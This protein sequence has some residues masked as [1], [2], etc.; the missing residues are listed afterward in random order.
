MAYKVIMK[1][2]LLIA[3]VV[4]IV[5]CEEDNASTGKRSPDWSLGTHGD[6]GE[7][8]YDIVFGDGDGV[9]EIDENMTVKRLDITISPG[10]W[11]VLKT[12]MDTLYG[13][14]EVDIN[15]EVS[16][17]VQTAEEIMTN[18]K[19]E[20]SS[21][22]P[23][24]VEFNGIKWTL[25]G[26]RIKGSLPVRE[27][28]R[29]G[30]Y[31]LPFELDFG[32]FGETYSAVAN[33]TFY[34]FDK[35]TLSNNQSDNSLIRE[36]TASDIFRKAGVPAPAATFCRLYVD[37]D[38]KG[39]KYFGMY[40]LAE[41]ISKSFLNS[42]FGNASGNIYAPYAKFSETFDESLYIRKSNLTSDNY[43]DILALYE[44][45]NY[46]RGF[47][48][49]WEQNLEAVFDVDGFIHWLAVNSVMQNWNTYGL[50]ENNFS[51]YFD[52]VSDQFRWIPSGG[53][54]SALL[55]GG[56]SLYSLTLSLNTVGGEWPFIR[57]ILDQPRYWN[58]YIQYIDD[59]ADNFYNPA[60]MGPIYQEAHDL[61]EPYVVGDDGETTRYTHLDEQS[62]FTRSV[63]LLNDYVSS[64]YQNVQDLVFTETSK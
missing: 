40:T 33:Q 18:I 14:F 11:N 59:T 3:V 42:S 5:A 30:N 44:A 22:R 1:L 49:L 10:N 43:D 35:L 6:S 19:A 56:E 26:I 7:P 64:R 24:D 37:L 58:K 39:K 51:L 31:K 2:V 15:S 16:N 54:N 55:P 27:L 34:G 20:N 53:N 13:E 57:F 25:A 62:D 46:S 32:V 60:V 45:L 63:I 52:T 47:S 12:N 29:V 48:D 23:C 4:M 50:M 17:R 21:W 9:A 61:I 28:W 41:G 36:K 8:D 38:G